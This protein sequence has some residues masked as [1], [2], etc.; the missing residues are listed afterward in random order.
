MDSE[1]PALFPGSTADIGILIPTVGMKAELGSI[2]GKELISVEEFRVETI[3]EGMEKVRECIRA[4]L[5]ALLA[6]SRFR[7]S[8][9]GITAAGDAV[10]SDFFTDTASAGRDEVK[11][12]I[13]EKKTYA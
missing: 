12:N 9:I 4:E 7:R 13:L 2:H 10:L 5:A 11:K 1:I 3:I 6:D 8:S